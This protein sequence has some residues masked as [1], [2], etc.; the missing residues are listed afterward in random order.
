MNEVSAKER[1]AD[2]PQSNN[3]VVTP[4]SPSSASLARSV[5]DGQVPYT[6]EIKERAG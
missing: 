2:E 4:R 1:S 3:R 5:V 6:G